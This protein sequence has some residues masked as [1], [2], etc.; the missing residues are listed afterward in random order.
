ML[1]RSASQSPDTGDF[2]Y[3]VNLSGRGKPYDPPP[4]WGRH[5]CEGTGLMAIA[6]LPG[7]IYGKT[8]DGLTVNLYA[9]S[10]LT[11]EIRGVPVRVVQ[12]TSWPFSGKIRIRVEPTRPVRFALS[13]RV[14][15]WARAQDPQ[16]FDRDWKSGDFVDLD[17]RM[18]PITI[19]DNFNGVPR[20]ALKYGPLVMAAAWDDSVPVRKVNLRKVIHEIGRASCRERVC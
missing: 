12:D 8:E 7:L 2:C 10:E 17:F 4:E 3:F 15:S 13:C 16:R 5:C 6:R 19:A 11:T 9:A 14:P 18:E 1:F 20:V